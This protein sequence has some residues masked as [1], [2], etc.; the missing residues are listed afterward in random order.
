MVEQKRIALVTGGAGFIGSHLTRKLAQVGFK[1]IVFDNLS[2][3]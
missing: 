2:A 1:V 3:S